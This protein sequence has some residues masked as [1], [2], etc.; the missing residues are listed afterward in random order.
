[1][2]DKASSAVYVVVVES[3]GDLRSGWLILL[4]FLRGRS[5][6]GFRTYFE[7]PPS[8]KTGNE[9][10]F[11]QVFY[12]AS[13]LGTQYRTEDSLFLPALPLTS[14]SPFPAQFLLCLL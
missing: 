7:S 9:P 12:V 10:S 8:G 4:S 11:E 5:P 3:L 2:P 14:L 6:Y 1:M 13:V